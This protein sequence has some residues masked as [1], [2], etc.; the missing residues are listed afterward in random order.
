[1]RRYFRARR[2]GRRRRSEDG[3]SEE[4]RHLVHHRAHPPGVRFQVQVCR[5]GRFERE[6]CGEGGARGDALAGRERPQDSAAHRGR[7]AVPGR[8][9]RLGGRRVQG[10]HV[11][12]HPGAKRGAS[13]R[14]CIAALR[15]CPP[16]VNFVYCT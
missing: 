15:V 13:V 9:V 7:R 8:G 1:M 10:A 4:G 5:R 16:V 14:Y 3:V 11:A 2:V 12:L 6:G